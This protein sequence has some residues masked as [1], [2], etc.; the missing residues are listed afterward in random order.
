MLL[1]SAVLTF[2]IVAFGNTEDDDDHSMTISSSINF[3]EED[4]RDSD[5]IAEPANTASSIASYFPLALLG[6]YGPP[7]TEWST[8][9]AGH[10]RFGVA[11]IAL[12]AIGLGSTTLHALL[13]AGAQGGDEL[14]MLWFMASLS[15]ITM[16]IIIKGSFKA[17]MKRDSQRWLHY[18]AWSSALIAT[19]VYVF[20]RENFLL[21]YIMFSLYSWLAIVGVIVICF[22]L[23]WNDDIFRGD[24]LLPLAICTAWVA[25]FAVLAWMS[26]M[27][28]CDHATKYLT[29]GNTIAPWIWNRAVHPLWHCSSALLAWLL[30]QV[31][32]AGQGLQQG[33]GEPRLQWFGVPY[34]I[35]HKPQANRT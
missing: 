31:L 8:H 33:W 34:V 32:L 35:F 6:F 21:F 4:F 27:L 14:P 26:E 19:A 16:D 30:I 24:V 11:Y 22:G 20:S 25:I 3:C 18:L 1:A 23:K 2:P 7:A 28:F 13:T 10:K 9:V 5:Y 15:F 17:T 29:F 12:L